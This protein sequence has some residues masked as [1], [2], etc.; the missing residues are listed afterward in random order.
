MQLKHRTVVALLVGL[1]FLASGLSW[2]TERW[3]PAISGSQGNLRLTLRHFH[4]PDEWGVTP[5][6]LKIVFGTV[7][8]G[9]SGVFAPA[10]LYEDLLVAYFILTVLL[11]VRI[12]H[13]VSMA[14]DSQR[15][16][17]VGLDFVL[18]YTTIVDRISQSPADARILEIGPGIAGLARFLHKHTVIGIDDRSISR[19]MLPQNLK[20][21]QGS[22]LNAPFSDSSFDYVVCVD[23]IEHLP[24]VEREGLIK[25]S[26]RITKDTLFIAA[27]SGMMSARV[28]RFLYA[29]LAP[30]YRFFRKDLSFL[31]EHI[32]KGLPVKEDLLR[33]ITTS[34]PGA[35]V[36]TSRNVNLCVWVVCMW[37]DP[38][39]RWTTKRTGVTWLS[40]VLR[41]IARLLSFSPE[42][43]TVFAVSKVAHRNP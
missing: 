1:Y 39:V 11:F 20:M 34:A 14:T 15:A 27:P 41:P 4:Q 42:Y 9:G 12:T 6:S 7:K 24:S 3:L 35:Q 37:L 10:W 19:S 28:E 16:Q 29:V 5:Q 31:R 32:E 40:G 18:R 23:V 25:E 8:E 33:A 30:F 38:L 26:L 2:I 36:S 22:A 43:R 21:I 13:T 17:G